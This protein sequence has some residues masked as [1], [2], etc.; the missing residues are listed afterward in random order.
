M[1]AIILGPFFPWVIFKRVLPVRLEEINQLAPLLICKARANSN[2]L[3]RSRLVEQ[4]KQK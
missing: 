1:I 4:S 2:M 3:Q